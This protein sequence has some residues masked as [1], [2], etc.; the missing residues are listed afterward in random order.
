MIIEFENMDKYRTEL[1]KLCKKGE[2]K[3]NW[4]YW[5][6]LRKNN[7]LEI[8]SAHSQNNLISDLKPTKEYLARSTLLSLLLLVENQSPNLSWTSK[9]RMILESSNHKGQKKTFK[10]YVKFTWFPL[11]VWTSWFEI[12]I[13]YNFDI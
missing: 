12:K 10:L 7:K 8:S 13:Y 1:G 3:S 4:F 2:L 5:T 11:C 6:W 9:M